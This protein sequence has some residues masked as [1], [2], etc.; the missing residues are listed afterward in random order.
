NYEQQEQ[1]SQQILSS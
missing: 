1:A